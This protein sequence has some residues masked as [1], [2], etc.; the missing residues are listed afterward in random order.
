MQSSELMR[1]GP[2]G[3][4]A[5]LV[6]ATESLSQPIP[7]GEHDEGTDEKE[8]RAVERSTGKLLDRDY[9]RAVVSRMVESGEIVHDDARATIGSLIHVYGN[10]VIHGQVE[11]SHGARR[12]S[13]WRDARGVG[14]L[15]RTIAAT[16]ANQGRGA[17]LARSGHEQASMAFH[18]D[19]LL[20]DARFGDDYGIPDVLRPLIDEIRSYLPACKQRDP[21][22]WGYTAATAIAN[23]A[24]AYLPVFIDTLNLER[25]SAVERDWLIALVHATQTFEGH[26]DIGY[27]ERLAELYVRI[28][29]AN[30]R[31]EVFGIYVERMNGLLTWTEATNLPPG[32]SLAAFPGVPLPQKFTLEHPGIPLAAL[33][34]LL[35]IENIEVRH[36]QIVQL[37]E[38]SLELEK[39]IQR[40]WGAPDKL[41]AG[42][43]QLGEA[44]DRR[45][46]AA[47]AAL[48]RRLL[49][50]K[51]AAAALAAAPMERPRIAIV[52]RPALP[53]VEEESEAVVMAP[54]VSVMGRALQAV[55]Q[56]RSVLAAVLGIDS[57]TA[58]P[59]PTPQAVLAERVDERREPEP[60][61]EPEPAPPAAPVD[62]ISRE[63]RL[64][65]IFLL[66]QALDV[67]Q[68]DSPNVNRAVQLLAT[69]PDFERLSGEWVPGPV[70]TSYGYV[71][72]GT[73]AYSVPATYANILVRRF[74]F[75]DDRESLFV[76]KGI[77]HAADAESRER[78]R[79]EVCGAEV[80]M[81]AGSDTVETLKAYPAKREE[82]RRFLFGG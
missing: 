82:V 18:L 20:S 49:A 60:E 66:A 27:L 17:G 54:P 81:G 12:L 24:A 8:S 58:I 68:H 3:E 19:Q 50:A 2:D 11:G 74:C 73:Q 51:E 61:P 40:Q 36:A 15:I 57:R 21:G 77:Y 45:L 33:I 14:C 16:Q 4:H 42:R 63:D 29:D 75:F 59:A 79:A 39:H 65:S 38:A 64:R 10:A 32:R 7:S 22:G 52:E 70:C 80:L 55:S 6:R 5:A 67:L 23:M 37:I 43:A 1:R 31:A 13:E 25:L 78:I 46:A 71:K 69:T 9:P 47:L 30:V 44:V 76:L 53:A 56:L 28:P 72:E 35:R 34:A 26:L 62:R 41:R 48:D